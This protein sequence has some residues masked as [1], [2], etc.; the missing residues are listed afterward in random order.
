MSDC[1]SLKIKKLLRFYYLKTKRWLNKE[2][3]EPRQKINWPVL[4]VVA[5][6]ILI[7]LGFIYLVS[8]LSV[9]GINFEYY[10]TIEDCLKALYVKASTH[11]YIA[12]F[13]WGL[14]G[15][16]L[17]YIFRFFIEE[18]YKSNEKEKNIRVTN[19]VIITRMRF[20]ITLLGLYFL[21]FKEIESYK[22]FHHLFLALL[23]ILY[24]WFFQD[25]RIA[26]ITLVGFLCPLSLKIGEADGMKLLNSADK[27]TFN[28]ILKNNDT[29][30]KEKDK[31]RYFI[32]KTTNYV[33]IMDETCKNNPQVVIRPTAEIQK[34]SFN[35]IKEK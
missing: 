28:I 34:M 24:L 9:F 10:F 14:I 4:V 18:R 23:I 6:P 7:L 25:K 12:S 29:I 13:V 5:V 8:F 15:L 1:C 33:F 30:L 3:K 16:C 32:Y 17:L 35:P 11:F 26:L 20:I 19:K 27:T 21:C 22:N 31:N 2:Y